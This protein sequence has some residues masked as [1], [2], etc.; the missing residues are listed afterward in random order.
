MP[1]SKL[2]PCPYCKCP[3]VY[4][5]QVEDGMC[6]VACPRCSMGGPV[7]VDGDEEEASI[8]WNALCRKLCRN[9]RQ[10]YIRRIIELKHRLQREGKTV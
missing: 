10:V 7:S 4:V 1:S 8:A 3:E 2:E 9:C 5:A 6:C